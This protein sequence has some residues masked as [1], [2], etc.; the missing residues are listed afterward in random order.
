M[1]DRHIAEADVLAEGGAGRAAG[2]RRRSCVP[3]AS[4][5]RV[6]VAGDAAPDHLE[7]DQLARQPALL[8]LEQRLAPTNVALVELHDP[9]EARLE[10]V[11]RL[12]DVVAVEAEARLEPQ[13]V[14]RAEADGL[15]AERARRPRSAASQSARRRRWGRTARR[16]PRRCSRCARRARRRPASGRARQLEARQRR[17]AARQRPARAR[18]SNARGPCS[19]ISA[20]ASLSSSNCALAGRRLREVRATSCRGCRRCRRPAPRPRRRGR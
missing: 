5:Q 16:R 13:R 6:A 7:A 19:A 18:T 12:V 3:S 14:A 1:R 11:G 20:V 2:A 8:A 17:G 9:A 15:Q 4:Q 10:R